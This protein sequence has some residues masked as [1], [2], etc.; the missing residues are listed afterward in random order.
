MSDEEDPVE[1]EEKELEEEE[2]EIPRTNGEILWTF[3]TCQIA[4]AIM[5]VSA[6]MVSLKFMLL[7]LTMAYFITFLMAPLLDLMEMRPLFIGTK[8]KPILLENGEI[9]DLYDKGEWEKEEK[10]LCVKQMDHPLRADNSETLA[11]GLK[12]C[13]VDMVLLGKFPHGAAVGLTFLVT[14]GILGAIFAL[15][16]SSFDTFMADESR[17]EK[18]YGAAEGY[19]DGYKPMSRQLYDQGNDI[20]DDLEES[21]IVIIRPILCE[22][23][24]P[25]NISLEYE[26]QDIAEGPRNGNSP[27]MGLYVYNLWDYEFTDYDN[28]TK[29]P[30][31]GAEDE[32]TPLEELMTTLNALMLVVNDCVLVILLA[33]Y[34]LM[35]RPEG[36]TVQGDAPAFTE[37]EGMIKNY[38]NL[39]TAISALTGFLVAVL[40]TVFSVPLGPIFGILAFL[41]NYIP[42]VGSVIA[43]V[44]PLPIIILDNDNL[45]ETSQKIMAFMGPALVQGYVG[46]AL[47]PMLFGASLNLTAM[48]ILL[49][50]V[51]MA[52]LWGLC[53]AILSVPFLGIIK[54]ACDHIE[55]PV[56]KAILGLVRE[57][58]VDKE[59]AE[60]KAMKLHERKQQAARDAAD[61]EANR[62]VLDK[63]AD[64][65]INEINEMRETN[66]SD[67][68]EEGSDSNNLE[69]SDSDEE[70]RT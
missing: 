66:N 45:P 34:I 12:S 11:G 39:K 68:D 17:K 60:R 7:P 22:N 57:I 70:D 50:L 64:K 46:N 55:H 63:A 16:G 14:I 44:L 28:C 27:I 38:I 59:R 2:E 69:N 31:F 8:A 25:G 37:I 61:K 67:E 6:A 32:G 40:L 29:E 5:A 9:D 47:E 3:Q 62:P 56:A 24:Y 20:V 33:S 10:Y 15:I 30:L 53:G 52:F 51:I 23:P 36:S 13:G 4:L 49:F 1:M 26:E 58:D 41:L 48:S 18:T 54:I 65:A 43:C 42:N 19:P 35:E 21:G